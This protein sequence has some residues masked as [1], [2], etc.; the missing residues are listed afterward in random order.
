MCQTIRVLNAIREPYI[1][2]PLTYVQY[3]AL[4][5]A[6]IINR[7]ISRRHFALAIEISKYLNMNNEEGLTKI[8]SNWALY[9]V[10]QTDIGDDK[11]ALMIK[12]KLG[13]TPGISYAEIARCAISTGRPGLAIKVKSINFFPHNRLH[14]YKLKFTLFFF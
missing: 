4:T 12:S 8:L 10:E 6:V 14:S 3:E 13:D 9:K 5:T 2:L 7:L 1:G 11:I